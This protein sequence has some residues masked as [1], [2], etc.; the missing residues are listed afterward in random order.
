MEAN[1]DSN[2][3]IDLGASGS[4]FKD[5]HLSG[6]VFLGGG[7]VGLNSYEEGNWT[8]GHANFAM[9]GTFS[10]AGRY[11]KV[12]RMVTI[13]GWIKSTGSIAFST[14]CLINGFPFAGEWMGG[15]SISNSAGVIVAGLFTDL[16]SSNHS[17]ACHVDS[18]NRR[19]FLSNFT[20]T[21]ANEY[22]Y[23]NVV[24]YTA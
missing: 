1:A 3:T 13:Q 21:A 6:S 4:R 10:S 22:M 15:S 7:G 5:L 16:P 23:I 17:P 8:P 19:A 24:Y 12:G 20:T 18:V 14:S 2:G 9:T 11:T